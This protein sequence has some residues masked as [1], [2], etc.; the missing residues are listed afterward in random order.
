MKDVLPVLVIEDDKALLSFLRMALERD[1]LTVAGATSGS[2]ALSLLKNGEFAGIISDL[3]LPG[4]IDGVQVFDWIRENRPGLSQR[5]LFVTGDTDAVREV[6][7]RTGARYLEKP[8]R[9]G[10]MMA[11]VREFLSRGETA[12]A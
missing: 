9:I 2:E 11:I 3:R 10:Q 4:A 12:Y 7:E 6:W 8:F 1:G 5:F